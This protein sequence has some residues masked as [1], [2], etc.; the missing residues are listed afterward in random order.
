VRS[1]GLLVAVSRV[2]AAPAPRVST[3]RRHDAIVRRLAGR[4]DAALPFRFGT[5]VG[6]APTLA[7]RLKAQGP[8]LR[9]ALK[10]VAGREQMTLRVYGRRVDR[11]RNDGRGSVRGS[12]AR[13]LASRLAADRRRR[14]VPE[15]EPLRAALAKLIV[16]ERAERHDR[17]PLLASVYH[18]VE[19][20]RSRAYRR[21]VSTACSR[22]AGIGLSISGPWPPYAFAPEAAA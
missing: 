4:A 13:Y 1:A 2:S 14:S 11:H 10:L 7:R 16:A 9:R 20:G 21:A 17:P 5:F 3:L 22:L 12:G 8:A 6:D 15:I 19:R 18:L